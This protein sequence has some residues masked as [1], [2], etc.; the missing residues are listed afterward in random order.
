MAKWYELAKVGTYTD[1]KGQTVDL[2]R[3]NLAA[4]AKNYDPVSYKSAITVGHPK[5]DRE[6]AYGRVA[7][8]Q[9]INDTLYF[10]PDEKS[11]VSEFGEMVNKGMYTHVSPSFQFPSARLK[12]VAFLGATPPAI[13]GMEAITNLEFAEC[14]DPVTEITF[15]FSEGYDW[16]TW[17]I[18]TAGR[19]F[20]RLRDWMIESTGDAAKVNQVID[21]YG[22]ESLLQD[23]PAEAGAT[24]VTSS[25]TEPS[26]QEDELDIK[27]LEQKVT[28]LSEKVT[29]LETE[30]GTLKTELNAVKVENA[31][32][33]S[34]IQDNEF[35]EYV[36][37]L[38]RKGKLAPDKRVATITVL[39][40]L[41]TDKT[42][43]FSEGDGVTKK[44]P[45]DIY[46]ETL[47]NGETIVNF[48]ELMTKNELGEPVAGKDEELAALGRSIAD[49]ANKK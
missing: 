8:L 17:K 15:E 16:L 46:K 24:A 44:S 14:S 31:N 34:A 33:K 23:P 42:V 22:I 32:L 25:F 9:F 21:S 36:G 45:L 10:Q 27:E 2:T 38:V 29:T 12:H 41:S 48:S 40:S 19:M 30:N 1:N 5:S 28:E 4:V 47:E 3:D 20:Q 39:K 7:A 13:K 49:L 43:E 6:P 35:S 11:I 37:G 18:R 26:S